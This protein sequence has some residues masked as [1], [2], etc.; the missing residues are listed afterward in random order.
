M[1][2]GCVICVTAGLAKERGRRR[3]NVT[4]DNVVRWYSEGRWEGHLSSA[5]LKECWYARYERNWAVFLAVNRAVCSAKEV[6]N[7]RTLVQSNAKCRPT[8]FLILPFVMPSPNF[9][10]IAVFFHGDGGTPEGRGFDS[11]RCHRIFHWHN[12]SGY[13]MALGSTQPLTEMRTR[14]I[15]WGQRRPVRRADNLST[16]MC[17]VSW[18]LGAS[19]SW[20][21]QGLSRPVWGLLNLSRR[22]WYSDFHIL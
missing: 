1:L 19:T 8:E 15:S 10:K 21:P 7:A 18:N 17:L 14:C 5:D 12:P 11:R 6:G 16:F 13:T 3:T 9:Y 22:R 20:N 2:W 4:L